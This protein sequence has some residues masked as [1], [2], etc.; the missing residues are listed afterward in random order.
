MEFLLFILLSFAAAI[1]Y[2]L[3]APKE[4]RELGSKGTLFAKMTPGAI[5][6]EIRGKIAATVF[7]RNKGGQVIRNRITPINRRSVGQSQQRQQ[8]AALAA[9][10][11]GLT[12]PQRDSWNSAAP[13]FPQSDNLGQTQ[14]LS[15]EQLY[16]RC[17]ANLL[18]SGNSQIVTAPSPAEFAVIAFTSLTA[19]A[20]DQA[21][22]LAFTPTVPAGYSLMLRA[23]A[24]ISAGRE[25]VSPSAFRFISAIAAAATSPQDISAAYAAVFGSI[26]SATGQKIFVEMFLMEDATGLAGQ[27][28]R[29]VGVV[30]AT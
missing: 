6:S 10:W 24:P 25:F 8:L 23:T 18:L 9:Q 4:Y 15:G 17:N 7:A 11:R 14:Y 20:D 2:E 5:I 16:V 30:L 3:L 29:G 21:I 12:Q 28:V 19:T 27:K 13:N 1:I 26:V 22:S